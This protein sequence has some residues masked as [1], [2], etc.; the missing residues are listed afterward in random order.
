[1]GAKIALSNSFAKVWPG[2][3]SIP[4]AGGDFLPIV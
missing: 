3:N 1:M 2:S 4:F